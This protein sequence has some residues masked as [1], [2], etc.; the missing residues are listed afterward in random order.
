MGHLVSTMNSTIHLNMYEYP[1]ADT[2]MDILA[3]VALTAWTLSF[4]WFITSSKNNQIPAPPF[5]RR[6]TP[7][8]DTMINESE[9]E[10]EI[11]T[12]WVPV[13]IYHLSRSQQLSKAEREALDAVGGGNAA[14]LYQKTHASGNKSW[15]YR[16]GDTWF[17][18][19]ETAVRKRGL[20]LY[21]NHTEN[22][23]D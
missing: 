20:D 1:T 8:E 15:R 19:R 7:V 2:M 14:H 11:N 5:Y 23:V 10:E 18:P 12:A 6:G 21:G 22:L 4:L 13:G 16:I 17:Y 3:T 9:E